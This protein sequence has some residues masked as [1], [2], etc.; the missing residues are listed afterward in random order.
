FSELDLQSNRLANAL[1]G[2][3]GA[4]GSRVGY[5]G[6]NTWRMPVALF[7]TAKAGLTFMPLNWRLAPA[8][9]A[10]ILQ[11]SD[12][13]IIFADEE[14]M[15][16]LDAIRER[17]ALPARIIALPAGDDG[18]SDWTRFIEGHPD[19]DA[20][21]E[22]A[23]SVTALQV[24]T[25]GTSG[26]PKGV[27]LAHESFNYIRLCEHLD[28]G[29]TAWT[30]ADTF[31]M[32]MPNFH[33]AGVGLML[34][35]LYNGGA[36]SMLQAFEP[37]RVLQAIR[38]TRPSVTLIVPSALQMLLEHPDAASTDFSCF[39]LC[40]YAGSPIALPLIKKAMRQMRCD[41]V[42][43]YGATETLG[44]ATFLRAGQHRLDDEKKLKSCGTPLPLIDIRIVDA[45][46][47]ELPA[48]QVG[49]ILI[50][51]PALFKGYWRKPAETAA[52]KVHGWYRTG[53]AGYRDEE[54]FVYIHDRVK[55]MIVSG[56]EN[57]YSSEV[58][59]ALQQHPAVA[60]VAVIG[61]PDPKWGEAVKALVILN[62]NAQATGEELIAF[63]RTLIGGYKVPKS[64]EFRDDFPRTASGKI[65]KALLRKPFW[66]GAGRAVG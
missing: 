28:T 15:G 46:G 36:V 63:C 29:V 56:G 48:G 52:A 37:A 16:L 24:Y 38:E 31:L 5:L 23:T 34:Q 19:T 14:L 12:C 58:E 45:A 40:M 10:T 18:A 51:T 8:E 33:T 43:W 65:Q 13:R 49:E 22:V 47:H 44:A 57:V 41:F 2:M 54:G 35:S 9:I 60:H 50:R 59:R 53:D 6:K 20:Q 4:T 42:Q 1:L 27:E 62:A 21:L 66:D 61:V 64:V 32:F 39:K 30:A 11:D 17:G 55:D 26:L 3:K 7:G 25:S